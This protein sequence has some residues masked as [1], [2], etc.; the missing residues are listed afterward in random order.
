MFEKVP[1]HEYYCSLPRSHL[2]NFIEFYYWIILEWFWKLQMTH[3]RLIGRRDSRLLP[4]A[5]METCE[6]GEGKEDRLNKNRK[7]LMEGE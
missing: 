2:L 7:R 6:E 4:L 5:K 1:T 3:L